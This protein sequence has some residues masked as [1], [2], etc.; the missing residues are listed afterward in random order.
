MRGFGI[1]FYHFWDSGFLRSGLF[2][3]GKVRGAQLGW[4][5]N[6]SANSVLKIDILKLGKFATMFS[7][8]VQGMP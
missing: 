8:N 6:M 7:M 3:S 2:H 4:F 1:L 5:L